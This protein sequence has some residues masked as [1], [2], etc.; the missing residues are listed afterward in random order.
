MACYHAPQEWE[1]WLDW[2]A[3]RLHCR[4]RWRLPVLMMGLLFAGGRRVGEEKGRKKRGRESFSARPRRAVGVALNPISHDFN[5][6]C[7]SR[8]QCQ[9]FAARGTGV[10][11][12]ERQ[13]VV[14]AREPVG[15]L[16]GV[17]GAAGVA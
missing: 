11:P 4:S 14:A 16:V 9:P 3:A 1:D 10:L 7:F 12:V 6:R 2:L 13:E 15:K 5:V 8:P 17:M